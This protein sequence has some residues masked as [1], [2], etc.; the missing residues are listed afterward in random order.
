MESET[1]C[2]SLRAENSDRNEV[3]CP[4]ISVENGLADVIVPVPASSK[5]SV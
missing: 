5:L 4:I 2:R 1:P 3:D